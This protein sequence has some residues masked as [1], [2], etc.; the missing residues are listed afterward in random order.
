[1]TDNFDDMMEYVEGYKP[2]EGDVF[3]FIEYKVT[4]GK[5][6]FVRRKGQEEFIEEF[7]AEYIG[8]LELENG[9]AEV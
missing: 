4:K 2:K 7:H 1:M 5:I 8:S 6:I 3:D 9:R